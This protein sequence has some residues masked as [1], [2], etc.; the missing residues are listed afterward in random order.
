MMTAIL[1]ATANL[2]PR[3]LPKDGAAI[4][5]KGTTLMIQQGFI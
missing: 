4:F 5:A 2:L 1:T 3:L